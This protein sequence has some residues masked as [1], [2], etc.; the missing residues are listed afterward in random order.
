MVK[1]RSNEICNCD[2]VKFRGKKLLHANKNINKIRRKMTNWERIFATDQ[3]LYPQYTR[4]RD[5]GGRGD[6]YSD[7]KMEK[8]INSLQ[9]KN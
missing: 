4:E 8:N 9:R 5:R 2:Y 3:G 1:P 7:R 6:Q